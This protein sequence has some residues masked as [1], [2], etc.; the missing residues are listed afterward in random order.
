[1]KDL[2]HAD[3]IAYIDVNR[4]VIHHVIKE[5]LCISEH[6][7]IKTVHEVVFDLVKHGWDIDRQYDSEEFQLKSLT[8]M[9]GEFLPVEALYPLGSDDESDG[10]LYITLYFGVERKFFMNL[11]FDTERVYIEQNKMD[12][13]PEWDDLLHYFGFPVIHRKKYAHAEVFRMLRTFVATTRELPRTI[14]TRY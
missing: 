12:V 4:K 2:N 3:R 8:P 11:F 7:I 14:V 1:M 10:F 5:L 9:E 6:F 13:D